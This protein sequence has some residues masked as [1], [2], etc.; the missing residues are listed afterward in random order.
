MRKKLRCTLNYS[1]DL[2]QY[3]ETKHPE[4]DD[5][6]I[7]SKSLDARHA[8]KGKTPKYHYVLEIKE[9]GENFEERPYNFPHL[10]DLKG[11]PIIVGT[12]PAGLF[13]ALRLAEYGV[14]SLL[15]ERGGPS[16]QRML[17]IAR[18]W[19]YGQL[20]SEN[21]VCFGE[22][23]AG[24]FSDGKLITRI[25]SPHVQYVMDKFVSLGAP[26]ETAYSSNPHLGSHHIRRLIG[27]MTKFLIEKKCQI[28][29]N[30]K[31]VKIKHHH[32]Q[33]TGI[34]T[35]DGRSF[36]S[37]CVILATGHSATDIYHYL[38]DE[39]IAMRPKNF[40]VGLRIEHPRRLINKIQYGPFTENPH[41]GA[42]RYHLKWQTDDEISKEKRSTY[43]FCMCP[44][45]HV[46]SSG[47]DPD[48]IV[49]NGMSNRACNSPWSNAAFVVEVKAGIDFSDKNI[50]AGLFFQRK[51]E[52]LAYQKSLELASGKEMPAQNLKDFMENR[53]TKKIPKSSCPSGT[54]STLLENLF[55]DFITL[56]LRRSIEAF[57]QQ[58]RGFISSEALCLAPETRTSAPLTIIRDTESL[59]SPSLKG[60][61][62]CGEGPGYAGGITSAAADGVR[63]AMKILEKEKD[64]RP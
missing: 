19:R 39:G 1:Q 23:G 38:S 30:T 61:Y 58:M 50:L 20:D 4:I 63:V 52:K 5:Y 2:H 29:Y 57:N 47:S 33:V 3:L 12:G 25:K 48:G 62:P 34:E 41:L 49:V 14:R 7:L 64:F 24:L 32:G 17:A 35:E 28:H 51:I 9:K 53:L 31:I 60:L 43:S 15:F 6:R 59:E 42:S 18:Y 16:Y 8:W 13:A 10:G 40:S 22:G 55:P 36:D 46:L 37:S 44:G 26:A 54:F 27:K 56:C 45:G 21:N 11:P